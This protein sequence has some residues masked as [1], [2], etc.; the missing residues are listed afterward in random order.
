MKLLNVNAVATLLTDGYSGTDLQ[1]LHERTSVIN[2]LCLC[3]KGPFLDPEVSGVSPTLGGPRK[4]LSEIVLACFR[5]IAAPPTHLAAH[6]DTHMGFLCDGECVMEKSAEAV[7]YKPMPLRSGETLDAT[8]TK[9]APQVQ[10]Q[11]K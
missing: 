1:A 7:V 4:D 2:D 10:G 11:K 6:V 8:L 3:N 5:N 9:T